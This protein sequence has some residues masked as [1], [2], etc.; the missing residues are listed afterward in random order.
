MKKL[1]TLIILTVF[2]FGANAQLVA[3][4]T[5]EEAFS[6]T[7]WLPFANGPEGTRDDISLVE[8]PLKS[9]LNSSD[10]V[11]QFVIYE[12]A[13]NWVG[14]YSDNVDA[15][16]FT[17]EAHTMS[18]MV[19]KPMVSPM[20]LK[21]EQSLTGGAD[22]SVTVENTKVDEW[23]LIVFDMSVAVGHF[24]TRLTFFPDFPASGS[25]GASTVYI[26]NFD[27]YSAPSSVTQFAAGELK[28]FPNPVDSRLS[29]QFPEM[30]KLTV[31]NI[32]GKTIKSFDF[33]TTNSKVIELGDLKS[34]IYFVTA[35][36]RNGNYSTTF[37]KK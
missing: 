22:Q 20:R 24:Y 35:E 29:V 8:N 30:T 5:F 16:E 18:V 25:N 34:G 9:D 14:M 11:L 27:N 19:L 36:T 2:A 28:I 21:L 6:D 13:D 12:P 7:L 31:S 3:P 1:F 37:M 33:L 17:T 26:D 15:M 4:V 23:E 10:S 32:L